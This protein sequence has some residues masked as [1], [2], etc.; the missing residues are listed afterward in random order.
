MNIRYYKSIKFIIPAVG[1]GGG[2]GGGLDGGGKCISIK[3]ALYMA[4]YVNTPGTAGGPGSRDR[5]LAIKKHL[6]H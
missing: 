5:T 1:R 4:V 6:L 3:H 2:W